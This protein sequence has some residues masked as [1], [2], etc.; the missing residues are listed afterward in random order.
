MLR[1]QRVQGE[2]T[3]ALSLST[4]LVTG[5]D[6]PVQQQ[7]ERESRVE[8]ILGRYGVTGVLPQTGLRPQWGVFDDALDFAAA[9]S[10]I[11]QA[12]VAFNELPASIREHFGNDPDR[13]IQFIERG[14][15]DEAIRIGLLP[16]DKP[17]TEPAP[18]VTEPA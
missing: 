14:D 12:E 5:D 11:R 4:G 8:V 1:H 7:F 16:P 18:P 17:V 9:L 10:S 2:E 15:K 6:S 3:D 13:F